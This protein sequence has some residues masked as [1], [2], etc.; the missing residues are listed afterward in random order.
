MPATIIK[1]LMDTKISNFEDQN[2]RQFQA[3]L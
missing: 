1:S 3:N 2:A